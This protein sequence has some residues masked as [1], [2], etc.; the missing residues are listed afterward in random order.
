MPISA[1]WRT[2]PMPTF[3]HPAVVPLDQIGPHQFL[4]GLFHGPTLAF[5]DVAM[6]LISRLMDHVLAKRGQ[7]TTIWWRPRAIPAA[8]RGGCLCQLEN[9][10]IVVLF[11]NGRISNVQAADDDD[12]GCIQHPRARDRRHL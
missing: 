10:D 11:P 9:V 8:A 7:R 1:A 5:K 2:R 3:R 12:L 6:Q 4:L